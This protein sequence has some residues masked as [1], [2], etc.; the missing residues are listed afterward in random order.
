ME[1]FE[2]TGLAQQLSRVNVLVSTVV[3]GTWVALRVFVGHGRSQCI[4]NG[5]GG[6]IFGGDEDDGFTL[7]L[8]LKF[9]VGQLEAVQ[10][11]IIWDILTIIAAISGSV[12]TKDFSNICGNESV[13][14]V[15]DT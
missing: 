8:N 12:S 9:L 6:Y 2:S 1:G 13:Y 10:V 7:T 4:E 15:G 5:A 14:A 3:S 11:E